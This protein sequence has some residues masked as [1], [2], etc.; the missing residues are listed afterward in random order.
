M[1]NRELHSEEEMVVVVRAEKCE[2]NCPSGEIQY[3]RQG[4]FKG[5]GQCGVKESYNQHK[6]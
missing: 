3:A 6:N 5:F 4:C 1:G 2:D